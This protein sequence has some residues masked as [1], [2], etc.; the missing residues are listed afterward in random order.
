MG[1]HCFVFL[2]LFCSIPLKAQEA[3]GFHWQIKDSILAGQIERYIEKQRVESDGFQKGLGFVVLTKRPTKKGR[4]RYILNIQY[5]TSSEALIKA[6]GKPIGY[7]SLKDRV[8]LI[9][10]ESYS[11][12]FELTWSKQQGR[13]FERQISKHLPETKKMVVK[14]STGKVLLKLKNFT[15]AD[16]NR[17]DGQT[18]LEIDS[19]GNVRIFSAG[20]KNCFDSSTH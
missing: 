7:S 5:S 6:L 11:K 17:L 12:D 13:E 19:L 18:C 2:F 14:D 1:K 15:D 16:Y 4:R 3:S 20:Y 9:F 10:D 8:V